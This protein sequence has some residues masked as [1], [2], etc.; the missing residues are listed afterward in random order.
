MT[1]DDIREKFKITVPC[2]ESCHEDKDHGYTMA[3]VVIPEPDAY[4]TNTATG[5]RHTVEIGNFV[6]C[7]CAV[8]REFRRIQE[9]AK[10]GLTEEQ[11][12]IPERI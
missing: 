1:E 8:A 12:V 4:I 9:A 6:E 5:T 3:C 11:R 10:P 7:C 2:C